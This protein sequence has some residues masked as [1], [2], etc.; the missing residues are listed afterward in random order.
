M[1]IQAIPVLGS[2]SITSVNADTNAT[3]NTVVYRDNQ[4]G[5]FG[6]TISGSS[7]VHTGTQVKNIVTISADTTLSTGT[8]ILCDGTSGAFTVTL[9]SASTFAGYEFSIMKIDASHDIT[10]ANVS[11]TTSLTSQYQKVT[12][13]SNGTTWF[14]S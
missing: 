6:A 14:C 12:A 3:V 4:G 7:I 5:I 1:S 13:V 11:G 2:A 9:P 10:I 8:N